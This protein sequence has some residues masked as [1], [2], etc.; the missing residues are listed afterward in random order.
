MQAKLTASLAA[1]QKLQENTAEAQT[2]RRGTYADKAA[3]PAQRQEQDNQAPQEF[4]RMAKRK[5]TPRPTATVTN[6]GLSRVYIKDWRKQPIGLVK[7][8]LRQA[9]STWSKQTSMNDVEEESEDSSIDI[10]A[11]RYLNQFG[12]PDQ[13]IMEVAC[14]SELV[15]TVKNFFKETEI[16]LWTDD[17]NPFL[18]P[19]VAGDDKSMQATRRN[20]GHFIRVLTAWWKAALYVQN[21]YTAT[22]YGRMVELAVQS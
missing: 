16:E 6:G 9:I 13:P 10:D 14:T 7:K 3:R 1:V 17:L 18:D 19:E 2:N 12:T 4:L 8:A 21:K 20:I 15:N 22:Y 11:V 5:P